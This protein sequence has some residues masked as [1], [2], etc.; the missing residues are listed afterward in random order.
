MSLSAGSR[1]G[2]YEVLGPLGAGGMGEVYRARDTK[3]GRDVALK[4]LPELF[5]ADPERLARFEREAQALGA[6]NHPNI[7]QIYGVEGDG[8]AGTPETR[9][10]AI[11]MELV[12]GDDLSQRIA[13]GAL[14]VEDAL[15]IARQ[16][17]GALEAAHDQGIVHR[18]LKPANIKVRDDGVVK[19]LDFGLAKAV[20]G[21]G[22]RPGEASPS[23]SPT[24][25]ARATQLGMILGTAAYMSPEQA[26]GRPVDKRADVWAFGVVLFEM[27]TGQR[28]FKGD[29]VS[30]T[31]ASVLAREPDLAALPPDTPPPVRRLL[32]R[33]LEKD[34]KKRL[35]DIGDAIRQ[36]DAELS[37]AIGSFHAAAVAAGTA[38]PAVPEPAP[39]WRRLLPVATLVAGLIAGALLWA[40]RFPA[41]AREAVR[42]DYRPASDLLGGGSYAHV[43]LS[44]DGRTIVYAA[45][46]GGAPG[47]RIRRLDQLTDSPLRGGEGG[48]M[49]FFSPDGTWVGFVDLSQTSLIKKVSILGGGAQRVAQAASLVHGATWT[50]DDFIVFA[51]RGIGLFEVPGGGGEPKELTNRDD[52]TVGRWPSAIPG[53]RLVLFASTPSGLQPLVSG[54]LAMLDRDTG[55]I[56]TFD[57]PGSAPRYVPTGHVVWVANAGSVMVAPFDLGRREFTGNSVPFVEGV[58]VDSSGAAQISV[59]DAGHLAYIAGGGLI[60][61]RTLVWVDRDGRE[62]PIAAEPRA[63]VYARLSPDE[64]RLS[65]DIREANQDIWILDLARTTLSRLTFDPGPDN[66]AEWF[67]DSDR[68]VVGSQHQGRANP[69]LAV[70]RANGTGQAE[71]LTDTAE[72]VARVPNAVTPDGRMVIF[73]GP[74]GERQDDLFMVPVDGDRKVETLLS[75][76]HA[77]LNAALSP[78]GRWM[79]FQSTASGRAEIYVK[80]FPNIND[81]QWQLSREGGSKPVWSRDGRHVFF[82]GADARMMSVPVD[83][84]DAFTLGTPEP[85]FDASAYHLS[86]PGRN[87]DV[88]KDGRFVMIKEPD[89]G[90][91]SHAITIVLNWFEE[92]KA[93][94]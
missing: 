41:P 87:Y 67:P 86:S 29:D 78:D 2:H 30:E 54:Q 50:S 37:G 4:V 83:A 48:S 19:V 34:P 24:L 59:T 17:A 38:A 43:A 22:S 8:S 13:G 93:I 75:T 76:E 25:T 84:R 23:Q 39:L 90:G 15:G 49:P 77:E 62:T 1:I 26:K 57:R 89:T 69:D 91:S 7:A 58:V 60:G 47:L 10:L 28:A 55:A 40:A 20:Q 53:T 45:R 14:P 9:S 35:R 66:Y 79:A 92:L 94:K 5:T 32:V 51:A 71:W 52:G 21:D 70:Y 64:T 42:F 88:S 61:N 27:L 31:L 11:A 44:P 80:P 82:V 65:L 16:I 18:D 46:E 73:R 33:C 81:G 56:T 63:Y 74:L 6:L 36:L 72:E 12:E 85:L 68:V 3:I